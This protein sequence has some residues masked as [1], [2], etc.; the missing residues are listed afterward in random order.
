MLF[1]IKKYDKFSVEEKKVKNTIKALTENKLD[2]NA[3]KANTKIKP[4][5]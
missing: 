2:N 5:H 1:D 3:F 4:K